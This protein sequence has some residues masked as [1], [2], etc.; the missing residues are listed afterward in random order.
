MRQ[1]THAAMQPCSHA[2][3]QP[4][5]LAAMQPCSH[6]VLQPCSHA[7][8][9]PCSH[10]AMQPSLVCMSCINFRLLLELARGAL[11]NILYT[12][13]LVWPDMIATW[14]ECDLNPLA[15]S[16]LKWGVTFLLIENWPSYVYILSYAQSFFTSKP[17]LILELK[18]KNPT[19]WLTGA[20]GPTQVVC[21]PLSG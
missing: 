5:S 11:T 7:A 15:L 1:Y 3:M 14:H 8:M 2:A 10:A 6:A 4:C 16:I 12:L 17:R 21:I 13:I 20:N 19:V 18:N 9:Q